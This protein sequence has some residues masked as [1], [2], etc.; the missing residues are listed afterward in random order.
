MAGKTLFQLLTVVRAM[1]CPA[2]SV[3]MILVLCRRQGSLV[4]LS[5][6]QFWS[7]GS[8]FLPFREFP[9]VEINVSQFYLGCDALSR[10]CTDARLRWLGNPEVASSLLM[11]P[12]LRHLEHWV[13]IQLYWITLPAAVECSN[14]QALHFVERLHWPRFQSVGTRRSRREPRLYI[15]ARITFMWDCNEVCMARILHSPF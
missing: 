12:H 2:T 1:F 13:G 9:A 15:S 7:S 4:D 10:F 6:P 5:P 14:L 11:Y 8:A 3:A